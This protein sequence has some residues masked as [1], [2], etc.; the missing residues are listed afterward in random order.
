MMDVFEA[1]NSRIA[2]RQF[3]D[4]PV[5]LDTV[6]GPLLVLQGADDVV[7]PANITRAYVERL[8]ARGAHVE[9]HEYEGEGHGWRRPDTVADELARATAFLAGLGSRS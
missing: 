6:R 8:C 2:C 9:Y 5:D 7:V 3:I 1:I 4:R